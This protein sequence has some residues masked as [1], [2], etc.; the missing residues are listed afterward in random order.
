[1]RVRS[2]PELHARRGVFTRQGSCVQRAAPG[3][4]AGELRLYIRKQMS[5]DGR[6]DAVGADQRNR[7][8]LL[9]CIAAA[10]HDGQ[11][12]GVLCHVLELTAEPQ[13]DIGV[14]VDGGLQRGLQIGAMDH[15]VGSAGAEFGGLAER[16]PGDFAAGPRAQDVDGFRR[17]RAPRKRLFEPELDQDAAGVGRELDAGAGFLEPFGLFQHHDAKA[18]CRKGQRRRQSPDPGA[19]NDDGSRQRHG[20]VRRPCLSA[21]IPAAA[22]RRRRGRA[23]SDRA[24]SNTGR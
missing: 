17:D 2:H 12:L 9:P 20:A 14:I 15:P 16:H 3:D 5:A 19:G 21:R 13:V 6:P 22:L 18:L 24:S 4:Q 11:A 23:R 1:M 7:Q 10:L 8:F